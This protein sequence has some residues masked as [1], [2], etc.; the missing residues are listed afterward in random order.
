VLYAD[1]AHAVY[2]LIVPVLAARVAQAVY[3]LMV[4]G[5]VAEMQ[6]EQRPLLLRKNR[7]T[8]HL[9]LNLPRIHYKS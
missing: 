5:L 6:V 9:C 4:V 2:M 7:K 3:T 8:S 1:L